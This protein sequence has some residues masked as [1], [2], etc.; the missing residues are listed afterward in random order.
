MSKI[1]KRANRP[2]YTDV[3]ILIIEKLRFLKTNETQNIF[4]FLKKRELLI[5]RTLSESLNVKSNTFSYTL[6]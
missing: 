4:L 5:V 3:P 2:G 6:A 1:T